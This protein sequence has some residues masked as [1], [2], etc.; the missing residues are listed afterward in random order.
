MPTIFKSYQDKAKA[1]ITKNKY[2]VIA[3]SSKDAKP[4][5]APVF[6]AYD[7]K[8]NFYFVSAI[9][10]FH[11][12]N[13]IE[14]HNVSIVI[15]DSRQAIG[16]SDGVQIVGIVEMVEKNQVDKAIKLYH[17]RLSRISGVPMTG[18]YNAENY[19]EPSEFR[20]FRVKITKAYT[21]GPDRR[22]EIDLNE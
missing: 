19:K 4:W 20:I 10:S 7:D 3:T 16:S 6:Y 9:D 21:T 18:N 1:I 8:F 22:V 5:A 11:V 14:N 2:M 15:F 12:K 13:I 17:D